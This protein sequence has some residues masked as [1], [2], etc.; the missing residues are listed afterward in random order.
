MNRE[1]SLYRKQKNISQSENW[2]SQR[3]KTKYY[4]IKT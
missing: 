1:I 2:Y 4:K 3:D